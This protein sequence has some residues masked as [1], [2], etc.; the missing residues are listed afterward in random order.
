V[1]TLEHLAPV[2]SEEL[3]HLNIVCLDVAFVVDH[4]P[5]IVGGPRWFEPREF[6]LALVLL[7]YVERVRPLL[8]G[9]GWVVGGISSV[10]LASSS[11]VGAARRAGC[12][13][14]SWK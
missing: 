4:C 8:G 13:V 2:F 3:C 7:A 12:R 9:G 14:V 10:R 6:G 1:L 11:R 5:E